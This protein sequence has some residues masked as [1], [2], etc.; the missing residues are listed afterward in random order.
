MDKIVKTDAEWKAQLT[1]QQ[2]A[3][4]RGKGTERPFCGTLLDNKLDGVYVCVCCSL[5]LFE[6]T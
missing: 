3:I 4:A 5:P 6:A 2:F 1:P